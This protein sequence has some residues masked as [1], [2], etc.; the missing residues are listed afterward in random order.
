MITATDFV[1]GAA[2][3]GIDFYSGVPCSYLTPLINHVISNQNP[4]TETHQRRAPTYV[5][6]TSEG[7][8]IAIAAG[9][10]LAGRP[11][12]VMF[13]NSGLG[14]AVNPLTSLNEPFRIPTLL[15]V[16]WRGRPGEIDEPQHS[17]MGRITSDLLQII[18]I[19]HLPFPDRIEAIASTLDQ[20]DLFMKET[21][22]PF[23]LLMSKGSVQE[24][25]LRHQFIPDRAGGIFRDY[26]VGG[27]CPSRVQI[28]ERLLAELPESDAIISTTG[29]CS[30][31]LF[32][33]SDR[34]QHLY[35]VGSM[36]GASA[37]ALG[38]A[39]NMR[40][41]IVVLDGDG[42]A[43]MKLGNMATIGAYHPQGFLHILLD[44]GVHDS[45]GGQAT[46]ATTVDFAR[47]ALSCGYAAACR[48]DSVEGFSEA[49]RFSRYATGPVLVHTRIRPGSLSPLGRPTL[50]PYEVA[51]R[52]RTFLKS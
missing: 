49:L 17:L 52:F 31:E 48:C 18:G 38:A 51:R 34:E 12:I 29:K 21:A 47:V 26:V 42:A 40:R 28:L 3:R 23:A 13:Q 11:N 2:T 39:L 36:G 32:T 25:S 15:I 30:R 24:F 5:G 9:S 8:V 43:L 33:L 27:N 10:W 1:T 45:T 35:Q 37:M 6:A 20:A 41:R 4:A 14:N 19:P 50:A 22:R 16:T 44:N 46:V 7:E